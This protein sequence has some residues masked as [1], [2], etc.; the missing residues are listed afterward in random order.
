VHQSGAPINP[1]TS[2]EKTR[3]NTSRHDRG[4]GKEI[5]ML[6]RQLVGGNPRRL[7]LMKL[8]PARSC[9]HLRFCFIASI[10]GVG[11]SGRQYVRSPIWPRAPHGVP[12]DLQA[13]SG[14]GQRP[15]APPDLRGEYRRAPEWTGVGRGGSAARNRILLAAS[16]VACSS[17]KATRIFLFHFFY[18]CCISSDWPGSTH[19]NKK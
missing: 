6:L 13:N 7:R 5:V 3:S 12:A 17:S 18:E 15:G 10:Q 19:P 9:L 16:T 8:N 1:S 11:T 14:K 2:R 4:A